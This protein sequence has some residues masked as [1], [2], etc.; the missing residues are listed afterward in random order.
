MLLTT[1]LTSFVLAVGLAMDAFAVSVTSGFAIKRLQVRHALRIAFFFGLFQ[2]AMPLVGWLAG[3]ALQDYVAAVD[4]WIAFG[5]LAA[6]GGKMIYEARV[7][8]GEE[9]EQA[10]VEAIKASWP[11][12]DVGGGHPHSIE[13]LLM[14]SV[15]TSIDAL[16]VGVSL[17]MAEIGIVMPALVIGVVTLVMSFGGVY[18]GK[19]IGHLLGSKLEVAGGILLIL[20]GIR[21][22][23]QGLG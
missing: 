13:T 1:F 16:A 17:S 6:V 19:R 12:A 21:I 8:S 7:L 2:A 11:G 14:L 20:I 23:V 10:R 22:L 15:A 5:L 18:L 9:R 3:Q 4:H